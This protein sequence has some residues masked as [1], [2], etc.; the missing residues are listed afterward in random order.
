MMRRGGWGGGR[1]Y[2]EMRWVGWGRGYDETWWVG[3][4]RDYDETR[5]GEG[6]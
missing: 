1:G 6:L 4:G 2:D 3:W 5:W